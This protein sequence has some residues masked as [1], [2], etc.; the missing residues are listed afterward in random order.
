MDARPQRLEA[1]GIEAA[2]PVHPES[3]LCSIDCPAH[4]E[5]PLDKNKRGI[6]IEE[7]RALSSRQTVGVL[8][9][10]PGQ[11]LICFRFRQKLQG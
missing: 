3:P 11:A 6:S 1:R 8:V 9:F 10:E 2:G 7:I 5:N 4:R